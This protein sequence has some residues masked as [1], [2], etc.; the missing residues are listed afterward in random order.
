MRCVYTMR[1]LERG[2]VHFTRARS[3]FIIFHQISFDFSLISF[4][5]WIFTWVFLDSPDLLVWVFTCRSLPEHFE[6]SSERLLKAQ[7]WLQFLYHFFNLILKVKNVRIRIDNL[8]SYT[9]MPSSTYQKPGPSFQ[10]FKYLLLPNNFGASENIPPT[11]TV[12]SIFDPGLP[13]PTFPDEPNPWHFK[14]YN[15]T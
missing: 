1:D 6:L 15:G 10:E 12:L 14:N 5:F 4:N 13:T 9:T 3:N 7:A 8:I 2:L 11:N